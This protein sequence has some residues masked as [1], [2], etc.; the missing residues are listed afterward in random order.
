L[1][2]SIWRKS[3]TRLIQEQKR[4]VELT[5]KHSRQFAFSW[6]ISGIIDVPYHLLLV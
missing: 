4:T 2:S 6:Q 5:Y 1:I 3:T